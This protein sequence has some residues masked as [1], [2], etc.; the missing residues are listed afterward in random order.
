MQSSKRGQRVALAGL[1]LQLAL[2]GLA[3]GLWL[4]TSSPVGLPA[5]WLLAAPLLPWVLTGL[6]F[7]CR[8]LKQ[9]EAEEMEELAAR[10]TAP[11]GIFAGEGE[12][13]PAAH[14][15]EWMERYFVPT[16]TLLIAAYH[17][18]VGIWMFYWVGGAEF[19]PTGATAP[20][21]F[22]VGGAF[23]AFLFSRYAT[24]MAKVEA[25]SLLRA[26]GSYLFVNALVLILVVATLA[27]EHYGVVGFGRV[28]G[29]VLAAL[30]V[31]VGFEL[32]L[33][34]VLDLY[35]PRVPGVE[36]RVGYDSRL[37]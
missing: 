36:R 11:E 7:H 26:P 9:R 20:I 27:L 37:L 23:A 29:Y 16:A 35:R 18:A 2:V 34:F 30:M 10:G 12:V 25:W 13:P 8:Y 28:A 5:V 32:V 17:L 24:G 3:I 1:A 4:V 14:R 31:V 22:A 21:F 19:R 15:L 6:L 33:N